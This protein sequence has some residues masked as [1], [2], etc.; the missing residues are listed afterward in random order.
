MRGRVLRCLPNARSKI[1]TSVPYKIEGELKDSFYR[2]LT[3]IFHVQY[4]TKLVSGLSWW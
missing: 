2:D 1:F 3:L 4:S